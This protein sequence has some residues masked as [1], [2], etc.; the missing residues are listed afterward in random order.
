MD[1]AS[2]LKKIH[3]AIAPSYDDE[4]GNYE[5]AKRIDKYRKV[6]L[7]YT[8]GNVLEV[9]IGTGANLKFYKTGTVL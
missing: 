3:D 7:S 4:M 6:L 1:K 5:W 8:Y 2:V 9:A